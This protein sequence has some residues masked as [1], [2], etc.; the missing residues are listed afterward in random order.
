MKLL[1]VAT[2]AL[3]SVGAYAGDWSLCAYWDARTKTTNAI[4][5]TRL[6]TVDNIFGSKLSLEVDAFAGS[7]MD[8]NLLGGFAIG[9]TVPIAANASV[10]FG[11]GFATQQNK[12]VGAGLLLGVAW[13]F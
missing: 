10:K 6:G 2:L 3:A 11:V 7:D 9:K 8:N 5:L 4:V 1:A 13:K 12:P